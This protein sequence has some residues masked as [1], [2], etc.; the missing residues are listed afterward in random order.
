MKINEISEIKPEY[1]KGVFG[2]VKGI[3]GVSIN[4]IEK[5]KAM[6]IEGLNVKDKLERLQSDYNKLKKLVPTMQERIAGNKEKAILIEKAK[7]FDRLPDEVK[8]QLLPQKSKTQNLGQE[9]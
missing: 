1:E 3:K 5:L 2:G 4:D 9:R 7:A 6:A 8:K